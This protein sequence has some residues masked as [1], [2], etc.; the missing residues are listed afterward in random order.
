MI[1]LINFYHSS[2]TEAELP[3]VDWPRKFEG[4]PITEVALSETEAGFAESF[5]GA[6]GV[7]ESPGGRQLILR[8]ADRPT[9]RLH[10]SA[11]CLKA[12][13]FSIHDRSVRD[14]WV[15]YR[16]SRAG[17]ILEVR[18]QIVTEIGEGR[19]TEVSNWF[20]DAVFHPGGGPWTAVTVLD[21]A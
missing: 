5:P 15:R 9:R 19:W 1:G 14:G 20:W 16:A 3:V 12:A 8:R 2:A 13:G 10:D 18:E 21:P 17:Q 7:F 6:I 4:H 11:T